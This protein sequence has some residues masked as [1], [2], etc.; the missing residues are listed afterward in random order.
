MP[1]GLCNAEIADAAD[2]P[3]VAELT[4]C[5]RAVDMPAIGSDFDGCQIPRVVRF[6]APQSPFTAPLT[7]LV[8]GAVDCADT[9]DVLE[10]ED[11]RELSDEDEFERCAVLRGISILSTSALMA[12]TPFGAPLGLLHPDL[13]LA[14]FMGGATAVIEDW[15]GRAVGASGSI[16]LLMWRLLWSQLPRT[17]TDTWR[18]RSPEQRTTTKQQSRQ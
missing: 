10:V 14:R 15:R 8:F 17:Y 9:V 4:D 6:R 3:D 16:C 2:G 7:P 18:S 12:L 5:G 1:L 11:A 13:L